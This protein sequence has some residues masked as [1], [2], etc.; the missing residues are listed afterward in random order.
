MRIDLHSHSTCSDGR[1]SPTEL[2][3]RAHRAGVDC[4]ALTD[5]D[6]VAGVAEARRAARPLG[7][8]LVSGIELSTR[9][10]ERRLHLLGLF[11]EPDHPRMQAYE[12]WRAAAR[13]Q[14]MQSICA[15]LQA[16]G[17][18]ISYEEVL[19]EAGP[20]AVLARPHVARLLV[21]R[22]H[23]RN[24]N[25]AFKR[26]L[27]KGC[28]AHVDGEVLTLQ[29]AATLVRD[30]GGVSALAHPGV[31][32]AIELVPRLAALGVDGVE[33][34]HPDHKPHQVRRLIKLVQD[35]KLVATG[36]SDFHLSTPK[37]EDPGWVCLPKEWMLLLRMRV[38]QQA[39]AR[40]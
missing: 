5:H 40:L 36:G 12:D 14:R 21:D 32:K 37:A 39:A 7:L 27:G 4:L 9:H 13:R 22:G 15:A 23:V 3:V 17:I 33:V 16:H 24:F 1:L 10:G 8:E 38:Q 30:C 19:A 34:F 28:P 26:W 11:L 35:H 31:D 18:A 2:V 29:E 25:E 20:A 6:T